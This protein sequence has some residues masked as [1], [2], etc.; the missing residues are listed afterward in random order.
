ML[1]IVAQL[2]QILDVAVRPFEAEPLAKL[3]Q[4]DG[5][6]TLRADYQIALIV[7]AWCIFGRKD[8]HRVRDRRGLQQ[9]FLAEQ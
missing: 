1:E 8:L 5:G 2:L 7:E 9:A 6:L 4:I 3:L